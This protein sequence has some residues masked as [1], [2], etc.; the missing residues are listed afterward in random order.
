[1]VPPLHILT[2]I[3][4]EYIQIRAAGKCNLFIFKILHRQQRELRHGNRNRH[5]FSSS[6][7]G[8][9]AAARG[10]GSKHSISVHRTDVIYRSDVAADGPCK[11]L[12]IRPQRQVVPDCSGGQGCFASGRHRQRC[13]VR[14]AVF[15]GNGVRGRDGVDHCAA[16]GAASAGRDRNVTAAGGRGQNTV[17]QRSRAGGQ[18]MIRDR[19]RNKA[20]VYASG[21]DID[22]AA[23]QHV[24]A[25]GVD[26]EVV[27]IAA[28]AVGGH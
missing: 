24:I 4:T 22:A 23:G 1:M 28:G 3:G 8:Q 7:H 14:G 16:A 2:G 26:I 15:Q 21:R 18:R 19:H 12:G 5:T 9:T 6:G 10:G 20:A 27:K 11:R 25:G 17:F 13:Q